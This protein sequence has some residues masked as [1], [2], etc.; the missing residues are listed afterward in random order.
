M[1]LSRR[2]VKHFQQRFSPAALWTK[3]FQHILERINPPVLLWFWHWLLL[4]G[5]HSFCTATRSQQIW[6]GG[7]LLAV[8]T[9]VH[10]SLC[11][12]LR[13]PP[14]ALSPSPHPWPYP[15]PGSGILGT[16]FHVK[17]RGPVEGCDASALFRLL[18]R[19]CLW[20]GQFLLVSKKQALSHTDF[21]P[22]WTAQSD[23]RPTRNGIKK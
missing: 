7:L 23:P 17:C 10:Q 8:G 11:V 15:E 16:F 14:P 18:K 13:P 6:T 19:N 22:H 20:W 12:T 5:C 1:D 2:S 4:T 9:S 21:L 3:H